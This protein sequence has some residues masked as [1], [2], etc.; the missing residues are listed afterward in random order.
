MIEL[1]NKGKSLSS[2]IDDI[3][4]MIEYICKVAGCIGIVLQINFLI[5][6]LAVIPCIVKNVVN[7]FNIKESN[8]RFQILS[9]LWRKEGYLTNY[10]KKKRAPKGP[11][12]Y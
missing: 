7:Y 3:F 5:A 6:I 12:I 9:S 2:Y 1:A 11:F 10:S 4:Q 8:R